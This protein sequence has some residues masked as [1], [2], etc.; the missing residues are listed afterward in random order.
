MN[1]K[2]FQFQDYTHF[3]RT[4]IEKNRETRGYQA[5][6][7]LAINSHTSHFS[8]VLGGSVHLTLDQAACIAQHLGMSANQADYFIALVS[9]ARAGTPALKKVVE[10]QLVEIKKRG[11]ALSQRLATSKDPSGTNVGV[12]YSAW[13]YSAM[14]MLL[15]TAHPQSEGALAE[16]LGISPEM[17]KK[18]LEVLSSLNIIEQKGG[19]WKVKETDLHVS[20]QHLWVPVYHANWRHRAAYRVFEQQDEDIHFTALHAMSRADF[21]SVKELLRDSVQKIRTIAA[22]SKEEEVFAVTIDAYCL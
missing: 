9:L 2:V 5:K 3:L 12:Y 22:P 18:T 7:A 4:L 16:R 14:H 21:E 8:R 13:H 11:Q 19:R 20:N 6:L 10:R 1:E 17:V 15:M